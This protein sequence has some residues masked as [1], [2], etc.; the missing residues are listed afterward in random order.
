M[1][2]DPKINGIQASYLGIRCSF[3]GNTQSPTLP[4]LLCAELAL[5]IPTTLAGFASARREI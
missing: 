2:I 3:L 5:E 4:T 1:V